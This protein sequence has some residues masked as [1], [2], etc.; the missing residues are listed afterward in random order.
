MSKNSA[1]RERITNLFETLFS[2]NVIFFITL[3][4]TEAAKTTRKKAAII[5]ML[6]K[7]TPILTRV[8]VEK[9]SKVAVIT[10]ETP[11]AII[12]MVIGAT[13]ATWKI[14]AARPTTKAKRAAVIKASK[15]PEEFH[16]SIKEKT[17]K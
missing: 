10:K 3:N 4:R 17:I 2:C 16:P 13:A 7:T 5:V 14:I 9:I 8:I 12:A 15:C 11:V 6:A 1:I